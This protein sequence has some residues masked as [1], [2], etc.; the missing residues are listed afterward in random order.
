MDSGKY[1]WQPAKTHSLMIVHR[2][3]RLCVVVILAMV[4]EVKPIVRLQLLDLHVG[5]NALIL[6]QQF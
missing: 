2:I 3:D 6:A 5:P 4:H 1:L